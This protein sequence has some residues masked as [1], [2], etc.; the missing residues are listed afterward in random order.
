MVTMRFRLALE[1]FKD[2]LDVGGCGYGQP[3]LMQGVPA[4]DRE[5]ELGDV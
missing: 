3:S 2:M 5:V 1:V 4:H